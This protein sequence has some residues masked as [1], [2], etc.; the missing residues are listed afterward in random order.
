L[1]ATGQSGK[2]PLGS[3]GLGRFREC[4]VS[5]CTRLAHEM[6]RDG[7][8]ATRFVAVQVC[9]AASQAQ[10]LQLARAVALSPLVKTAWFGGDPNWG[11][12]LAVCGRAG[13]EV[14]PQQL[15]LAINGL[16]VA[17]AG[18]DA[19]G[20]TEEQGRELMKARELQISIGVG[21]GAAQATVWTCDLGY[22][23]VRINAE[24]HT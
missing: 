14:D 4:L 2:L 20:Y 17:A 8:G 22:E 23:Y 11:R 1:L 9:E 21:V 18:T 16:P 5:I 3:A 13:V 19:P 10:A 12:V 7:E 24:Y 6:V 15:S